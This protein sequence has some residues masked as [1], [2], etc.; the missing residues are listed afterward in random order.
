METVGQVL[1]LQP[2]GALLKHMPNPDYRY[3]F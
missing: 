1:S 3:G 2:M